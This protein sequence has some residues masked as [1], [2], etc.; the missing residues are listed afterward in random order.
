MVFW[1]TLA[2]A[3]KIRKQEEG[4]FFEFTIIFGT[5][6]N[7]YPNEKYW[8]PKNSKLFQH[9]LTMLKNARSSSP[10]DATNDSQMELLGHA[11]EVNNMVNQTIHDI[12]FSGRDGIGFLQSVKHLDFVT[13]TFDND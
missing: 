3:S 6:E 9:Y 7:S 13:S 11:T 5:L 8:N 4:A 2:R 10:I 12:Q 1:Q